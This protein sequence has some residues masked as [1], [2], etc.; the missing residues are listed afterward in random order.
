MKKVF[1][2]KYNYYWACNGQRIH[3]AWYIDGLV[4][5]KKATLYRLN[6]DPVKIRFVEPPAGR[7]PHCGEKI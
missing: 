7:C 6:G 2:I 5:S 1:Q 4:G 3:D